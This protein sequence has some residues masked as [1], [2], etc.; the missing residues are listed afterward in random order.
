M[1]LRAPD[2]RARRICHRPSPPANADD[3]VAAE[4]LD[5]REARLPRDDYIAPDIS[6]FSFAAALFVYARS[7]PIGAPRYT[8]GRWRRR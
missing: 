1:T 7:A 4:I 3:L 2:A 6:A 8:D 5:A